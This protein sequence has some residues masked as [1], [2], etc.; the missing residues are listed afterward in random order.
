MTN[1]QIL[2]SYVAILLAA[3]TLSTSALAQDGGPSAPSQPPPV[4][5]TPPVAAPISVETMAPMTNAAMRLLGS[6]M[7]ELGK[8]RLNK[9][10]RSVSFPAVVNMR[11]GPVEYFLVTTYG[12]T[13]ESIFR[14]EAEPYHIH[15]AMLLLDAKG[16]GTNTPGPAAGGPVDRPEPPPIT[17]DNVALEVSWTTDGKAEHHAAD[18]LVFNQAEHAVMRRGT[19]IYNGSMVMDGVFAAQRDGSIISLI[20]DAAALINNPRPGSDN[21]EIWT[22]QTNNLPN[23]NTPVKITIKLKPAGENRSSKPDSGS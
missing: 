13:H 7:F 19:W 22:T 6:G 21:D 1:W 14:T 23:V 15:L 5:R 12:K 18:E 3:G 16:A 20:S 10:E 8:L 2:P 11:G 17:G 9:P 4:V